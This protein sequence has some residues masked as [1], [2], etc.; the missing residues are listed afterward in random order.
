[1]KEKTFNRW[2][3]IFIV[4]GMILA[5]VLITVLEWGKSPDGNV[6][7]LVAG[8][9]SIMGVLCNVC[10]ANGNIF[11]FLFGFFDVSIYAAMCF[12]GTRYG[13][14]ALYALF[15]LPMQFVGFFQWKHRGADAQ[16]QVTA[17]RFTR[18]QT[19]LY[20][21]LF[22]L[23]SVMAYLILARV[24][25]SAADSFIKVAVLCDAVSMVCNLLGQLL[26]TFAYM[27]QWIFWIAVNLFTIVMWVASLDGPADSYALVLV[28]KYAFFLVNSLNGLRVWLRLSRDG[29]NLQL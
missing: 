12:V 13:N 14:A 16:T 9:G 5:S 1:M 6:L 26:M 2:F 15:F 22:L 10:S 8:F 3:N 21:L 4:V 11:T 17:R 7:L 25:K 24:D 23:G 18:K 27:E 20:S 19:L 29:G 28:V